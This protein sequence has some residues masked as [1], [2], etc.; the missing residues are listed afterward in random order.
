MTRRLSLLWLCCLAVPA[1]AGPSFERRIA[2]QERQRAYRTKHN[3]TDSA[4]LAKHPAAELTVDA[5]KTAF[6]GD[7]LTITAT[8]SAEQGSLFVID[9]DDVQIVS[10]KQTRKAV[11]AKVKVGAFALPRHCA[12]LAVSPVSVATEEIPI[13]EVKGTYTWKLEL[14]NRMKAQLVTTAGPKGIETQSTWTNGAADVG[15]RSATLSIDNDSRIQFKIGR[16]DADVT[17]TKAAREADPKWIEAAQRDAQQQAL[18]DERDACAKLQDRTARATCEH[19]A[20]IKID[21]LQT[22]VP[23]NRAR[24]T[25]TSLRRDYDQQHPHACDTLSLLV[26]ARGKVTGVA[27]SCAGTNRVDV[28]GSL[29]VEKR[30]GDTR[31][32]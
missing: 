31:P 11:T 7:V 21:K 32:R 1:W 30:H 26:D 5:E 14:A 20:N 15:A 24:N 4:A 27:G 28:A 2:F 6:P 13:L 29:V 22:K 8:G 18:L 17:A 3:I 19:Q 10:I 12:L 16:N 23:W 9:C 25:M